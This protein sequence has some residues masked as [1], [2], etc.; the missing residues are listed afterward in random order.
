MYDIFY[1]SDDVIDENKWKKFQSRFSTATRLEN[2]KSLEQIK[3]KAFTK[4]FWVVWDDLEIVEDFKFDYRIPEWDEQYIHVFKNGSHF[5]GVCLFS[6]NKTVSDR[7]FKNRFF[8]NKKEIDIVAS[9]YISEIYDI[10]FISYQEPNADELY[11]DLKNRFPRAKRVQGIKGIHQAHIAAAELSETNMFWVVDGDARISPDFN[12]EFNDAEKFTVYVWTSINPINKLRYGY[13]GVK[14][15]PKKLTLSMDVNKPDMTTSI[16]EKFKIIPTISNTTE[17]NIDPFSTWRSAFRECV[18]LS[19]RIIDRNY[20]DETESRLEVWCTEGQTERYGE[21][22]IE[23][24]KAGRR[25]GY[26]SIGDD[27]ALRK[28]N[29][30][31]WLKEKYE[32]WLKK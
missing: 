2:I 29:D 19:S 12:F 7:E 17:F 26:D 1:I 32:L 6:K 11:E 23:G 8:V 13:G 4:F 9:N 24:A 21:Y 31:D 3:P 18:K 25:Y 5:N 14:L 28:I 30:F 15:L 10:I 16:S 20:D 22:A 27:N